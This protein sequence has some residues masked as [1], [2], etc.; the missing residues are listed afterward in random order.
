MLLGMGTERWP[1]T[2]WSRRPSEDERPGTAGHV[3]GG[4]EAPRMG[5][6]HEGSGVR[7]RAGA[8]AAPHAR[9]AGAMIPPTCVP[10]QSPQGISGDGGRS[11]AIMGYN[12]SESRSAA[13]PRRA[14]KGHRGRS[15]AIGCL[16]E[17]YYESEGQ[18]FESLRARQIIQRLMRNS[19]VRQNG[20]DTRGIP[21][22]QKHPRLCPA[23]MRTP[24][25]ADF[26]LKLSPR[27]CRKA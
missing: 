23:S 8:D 12:P 17:T 5:G 10:P 22:L 25:A 18:E 1:E 16:I 11:G 24:F 14:N 21:L 26:I 4:G 2:T 9:R 15:A 7:P 27:G 13:W 19:L 20:P 6:T 3:H